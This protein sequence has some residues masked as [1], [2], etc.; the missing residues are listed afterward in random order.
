MADAVKVIAQ[1]AFIPASTSLA[2]A[3]VR[4][5]LATQF[6]LANAGTLQ[7]LTYQVAAGTPKVVT[8][9]RASLVS[10]ALFVIDDAGNPQPVT[11]SG[12]FLSATGAGGQ[13]MTQSQ[14]ITNANFYLGP[15]SVDTTTTITNNGTGTT[16]VRLF[17]WG[18]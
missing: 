6:M 10:M 17:F 8:L 12:T 9:P 16:T 15:W 18:N 3:T 1:L 13:T 4:Q 14:Q 5:T 7:T 11:F 2:A